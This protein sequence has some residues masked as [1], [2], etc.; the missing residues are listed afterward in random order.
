[1]AR[2]RKGTAKP[3]MVMPP[4]KR[5]AAPTPA[6]A[7]PTI[8]MVEL[9]AAAQTTDPTSKMS[10]AMIYVHLILKYVYTFPKLGWREVVVSRYDEPYQPTSFSESKMIVIFGIAVAAFSQLWK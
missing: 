6:T 5:A 10:N 3:T 9:T 8:N 4:E 1:M 2:F 7:R